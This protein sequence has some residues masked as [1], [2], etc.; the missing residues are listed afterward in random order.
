ML[1]KI[2]LFL[3]IAG[4]AGILI[5]GLAGSLDL[6]IQAAYAT[7]CSEEQHAVGINCVYGD[8]SDT[9]CGV[10][11]GST[12]DDGTC[13]D[14]GDSYNDDSGGDDGGDSPESGTCTSDDD[15][16]T[17]DGYC[18]GSNGETDSVGSCDDEY[19][20]NEEGSCIYVGPA[21]SG[22]CN[23]GD[24]TMDADGDVC[25]G[26]ETESF[27]CTTDDG[28]LG[29]SDESSCPSDSE[30][31]SGTEECYYA[32]DEGGCSDTSNET[33]TC[34][35]DNGETYV[36]SEEGSCGGDPDGTAETATCAYDNGE[37]YAVEDETALSCPATDPDN[38]TE[39]T[40]CTY[41]N[42]E[43]GSGEDETGC[44]STDADASTE[45]IVTGNST[46]PSGSA[47]SGQTI[48]WTTTTSGY[49]GGV[50][51][52]IDYNGT[53]TNIA[54]SP[55]SAT[56]SNDNT[57]TGQYTPVLGTSG[58]INY[59][60]TITSSNADAAS[61]GETVPVTGSITVNGVIIHLGY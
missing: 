6:G 54:M 14:S 45:A 23:E 21:D 30:G 13:T 3:R 40:V 31:S 9:V 58:T 50:N 20:S 22:N 11:D 51:L 33:I 28:T 36:S 1:R 34:S 44:P 61:S 29:Y 38:G 17:E 8:G 10:D 27:T 19:S 26:G 42:G 37:T 41:D 43:G 49:A 7:T 46:S 53:V 59:T 48:T 56:S 39:T 15:I 60:I 4:F 32:T 57:W 52:Y 2:V 24:S 35:A 47:L 18:G 55:S 5:G 16:I 12:T 25:G